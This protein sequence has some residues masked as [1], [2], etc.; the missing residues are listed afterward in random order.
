ME[1]F[2]GGTPKAIKITKKCRKE[3]KDWYYVGFFEGAFGAEEVSDID[4]HTE[5]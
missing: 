4:G 5:T 2:V 1:I 3:H